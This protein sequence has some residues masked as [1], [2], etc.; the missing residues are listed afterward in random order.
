MRVTR[1][2]VKILLGIGYVS[3]GGF[4]K[5]HVALRFVVW[6]RAYRASVALSEPNMKHFV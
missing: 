2:Q 5:R 6:F 3:R 1:G 4:G